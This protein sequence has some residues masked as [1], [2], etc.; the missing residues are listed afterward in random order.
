MAESCGGGIQQTNY[1]G[2]ADNIWWNMKVNMMN[3]IGH[4]PGQPLNMFWWWKKIS[5]VFLISGLMIV[6]KRW[7]DCDYGSGNGR[8]S[9]IIYSFFG[10]EDGWSKEGSSSQWQVLLNQAR[11]SIGTLDAWQSC[12]LATTE[13]IVRSIQKNLNQID[14]AYC[15]CAH[16]CKSVNLDYAGSI[17]DNERNVILNIIIIVVYA[18]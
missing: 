14:G 13:Q 3:V 8:S 4:L 2:L 7:S 15:S 6:I 5:L 9:A 17:F 1:G 12:R 11:F 18:Q 16:V 10:R